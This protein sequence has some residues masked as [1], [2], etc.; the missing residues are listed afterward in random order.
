MGNLVYRGVMRSFNAI[1]AIA[2]RVVVAEVE[3]MV[4][5]GEIDPEIVVTPGIF[6]DRI[7][8]IPEGKRL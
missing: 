7:V 4:E 3:Q 6:I 8:V 2:A 1:M 5:A